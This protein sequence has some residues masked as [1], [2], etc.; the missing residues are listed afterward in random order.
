MGGYHAGNFF[1]R[2][3][4]LFDAVITLSGLFQ[5][6]KFVGDYMDDIVYFNSPLL[7]LPNMTDEKILE[8]YRRSKIII[9]SGQ[10]AWE[11]EMVADARAMGRVLSEK[12]IP[13]WVDLW[14]QDVNH[15]WP[16]WQKQLPYFL[17]QLYG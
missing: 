11:E 16:W 7:F 15:D 8:Q 3:P 10:G 4:D 2:H 12:G 5:L 9:C 13:A 6:R 17:R 1:F 14:G